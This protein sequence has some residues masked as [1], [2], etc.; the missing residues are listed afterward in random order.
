[1]I[2]SMHNTLNVES[3]CVSGMIHRNN[4]GIFRTRPAIG[5][6][7]LGDGYHR[8]LIVAHSF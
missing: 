8:V 4:Q 7:T 5:P 1:M 6:E 3:Y 2:K